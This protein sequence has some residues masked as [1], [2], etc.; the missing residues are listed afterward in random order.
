[1]IMPSNRHWVVPFG[2]PRIRA[3]LRLP[4]AY[5]NLLRP[6]S[7][8]GTKASLVCPYLLDKNLT[9]IDCVDRN[10]ATIVFLPY[11]LPMCSF[12]RTV[13]NLEPGFSWFLLPK[14]LKQISGQIPRGRFPN[15]G[16]DWTR[17]SD[18]ALIKRML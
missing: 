16:P 5:R 7:P 3:C 10:S 8:L 12:Q 18:P 17:T 4:V 6:S 1:M 9:P 11:L 14:I 15:G 13:G 2:D